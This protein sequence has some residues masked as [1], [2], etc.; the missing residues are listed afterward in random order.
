V[1]AEA[2]FWAWRQ[3]VK[4]ASAKLVLLCMANCHNTCTG[5]C[6]PS[7]VFLTR[8]TGLNRKTVLVA[9]AQLEEMGAI[10]TEKHHGCSTHYALLTSTD[11]GTTKTLESSPEIGTSP[12]NG[13][14][15]DIGTEPV[16]K[17]VP[18]P[19]PILGHEPKRE[20]K[21]NFKDKDYAFSG[22]T[23]RLSQTDFSKMVDQYP[24]LNLPTEIQQLDMELRGKRD[25]FQ[26][27][28]AK[29]NYRNKNLGGGYGQPIR[30]KETPAE[31]MRAN[32]ARLE[33]T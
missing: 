3:D 22:E 14:S 17:S 11:I 12:K 26:V 20:S 28:H 2:T 13:T 6:N 30:P 16:P 1:S 27:M 21:R 5:Q 23:I 4:P 8:N 19:V 10:K 29:L 25:W 31:R 15:T 7:V 9:I 33:A 32:L 18:Q 24:N